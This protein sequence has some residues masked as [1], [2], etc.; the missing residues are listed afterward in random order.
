MTTTPTTPAEP[1]AGDTGNPQPQAGNTPPTE[2]QAGDSQDAT[3]S[4]E[5]LKKLRSEGRALRER[6]KVAE[7]KAAELD[8]RNADDAAAKLS[9]TERL[10]KQI[11]EKD[12]ALEAATKRDQEYRISTE[13]KLQAAAAGVPPNLLDRV[14]RLIGTDEITLENGTPTNIKELMDALLKDMPALAG[15]GQ[16]PS[17]SGGA[18]NPPRSQSNTPPEI[19]W[20]VIGR[21][22]PGE[23]GQYKDAQTG[24]LYNPAD[25][26]KWQLNNPQRYG[27][28]RHRNM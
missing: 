14:V 8:K 12:A 3:L 28:V 19:N 26:S 17:T 1:Q 2:P 15:K 22:T 23:N 24:Q 7:A 18:T 4:L 11:A 27:Q 21:L 10:Q 6:L 25:V 9:E 5:E 16:A 20:E 13:I